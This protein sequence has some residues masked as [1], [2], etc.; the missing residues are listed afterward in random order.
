MESTIS[1]TP[2]VEE[3]PED[4]RIRL[5]N[6]IINKE[7]EVQE[8]ELIQDKNWA[9]ASRI[10]Y[11]IEN[12]GEE[13]EGDDAAAAKMGLNL[14]SHISYNLSLGTVPFAAKMQ[15]QDLDDT[16]KIATRYLMETYDK[17]D[18]STDGFLRFAKE[19]GLDPTTYF[20]VGT[21]GW[22]LAGKQVAKEAAKR[23]V[24]EATKL[25][26]KN[27]AKSAY[28]AAALEG[29]A[30]TAADD[31]AFQH[32]K[33]GTGAQ[34][35]YSPGQ[36][37]I[38][39]GIGAVLAP[40]AM[41]GL[42][43]GGEQVVKGGRFLKDELQAFK[44]TQPFS[45]APDGT[46]LFEN[47]GGGLPTQATPAFYSML[48]DALTQTKQKTWNKEQLK[49]FLA[50]QGVKEDELKWS[51][52]QDYLDDLDG[53]AKVTTQEL[54]E[55]MNPP[56]LEKKVLGAG[57]SKPTDSYYYNNFPEVKKVFD[58][59]GNNKEEFM[60]TLENDYDS[61]KA[62]MAKH[63][64]LEEAED[65]AEIVADDMFSP[66]QGDPVK[67]KKW[68][69]KGINGNNYREELTKVN[70]P[71][72][73]EIDS[74]LQAIHDK[75]GVGYTAE[76]SGAREY[77]KVRD[78]GLTP[79][80][81]QLIDKLV[82][83][84]DKYRQ[85]GYRS[86]HWNEDNVLYH[87]RKQDV[88]IDGDNTL[89]IEEIQSDWH[90]A[91][92]KKGYKGEGKLG[93]YMELKD[94]ANALYEKK[95]VLRT[96]Y[97]ADKVKTGE[98]NKDMFNEL[99]AMQEQLDEK[100]ATIDKLR[101]EI[102]DF[103][104]SDRVPQAPYSKTWH[105]KA[106]K[107]Q[108]AEA[109]EKGYE[110][111]AWVAGKEQADRYSLSKSLRSL[112]VVKRQSGEYEVQM[113]MPNGTSQTEYLKKDE[114][115]G[116][117]GQE[118]AEKIIKDTNRKDNKFYDNVDLEVGGEGMKGFYDKILPK[119]TN[120]YIKKYGSKVEVKKLSNGQEVWSFKVTDKMKESI[121]EKG[122]AL[123]SG[124]AG[125]GLAASAQGENNGND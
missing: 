53:R 105:E 74:E 92:R 62:L 72:V 28:G 27:F 55:E 37:A 22:G 29:A 86:S 80:D 38:A 84:K 124:A 110:R 90:Q 91:G 20:G 56:Q 2:D 88:D 116:A 125:V 87:T 64:E 67:Y 94:E 10:V 107:D 70:N 34:Q 16:Q 23:T 98:Y 17:K 99:K 65:W 41:K 117:L 54:L 51:G 49:G 104:Y 6:D 21:F 60:L 47:P 19:V 78:N 4:I 42:L 35:E 81:D 26:V 97:G 122:Q 18:V 50:K 3:K 24:M 112:G 123:Y 114:L 40:V 39:G 71:R 121:R 33:M 76:D 119:W 93:E 8:E 44:D 95:E 14:M 13:F 31:A 69:T 11:S 115:A 79:E 89:L 118:M 30:Y 73:A 45:Y 36:T 1:Y 82:T 108:I 59:Y 46:P 113:N 109:V 57:G 15:T 68:T 83:E 5:A 102:D 77:R 85:E 12:D 63:P 106:M 96:K 48:S 120:K 25:N 100:Y 61:Y 103:S 7:R 101:T 111:V 52:I 75:Y 58:D 32:I 66:F 9:D 43:V